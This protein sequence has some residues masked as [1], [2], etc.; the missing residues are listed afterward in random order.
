M[1]LYERL[2]KWIF[3]SF[4][5]KCRKNFANLL[6]LCVILFTLGSSVRPANRDMGIE[7][8]LRNADSSRPL[9]WVNHSGAVVYSGRQIV[10]TAGEEFFWK[11]A[12]CLENLLIFSENSRIQPPEQHFCCKAERQTGSSRAPPW[13]VERDFCS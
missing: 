9:Q 7:T 3:V 8:L 6:L 12:D 10:A 1:L 2:Y 4:M 13:S 5:L 11:P